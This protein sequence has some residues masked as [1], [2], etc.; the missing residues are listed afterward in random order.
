M[1]FL[2]SQPSNLYYAWQTEVLL[3]NMLES[4]V[5]LNDVEIVCSGDRTKEWNALA[6]SYAAHFFFYPVTV[7]SPYPSI[8]RP[9]AL[10]Q[11]FKAFPHL[12]GVA[13]LYVDCDI[14]FLRNPHDF[15]AP[16]LNDDIVY[17][18]D[19]KWYIGYSYLDSK[20]KDVTKLKDQYDTDEILQPLCEAVG[21]DLALLKQNDDHSGG[22]QYLLK[23]ADW[24]FWEEV[25]QDCTTI[26]KY[27]NYQFPN[28]VNRRYFENENAGFQSF[29]SDMWAVLWNLW[30]TGKQTRIAKELEFAWPANSIKN[31]R[32]YNIL[33]NAG[34]VNDKGDEFYKAKYRSRLP[35]EDD[36]TKIS[37]DKLSWLY[38]QQLINLKDKTCLK[39]IA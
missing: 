5:N 8:G 6:N 11:H 12:A 18:S 2:L 37:R 36:F 29:C 26:Y 30:K 22:A 17:L 27:F 38:V 1:K 4:G 32:N 3:N 10:K 23:D 33:H 7:K 25:E 14:L 21:L 28:S 16:L 24:K 31:N 39:N 9:N 20:K 13:I 19:T 15:L 35:Y 34:V